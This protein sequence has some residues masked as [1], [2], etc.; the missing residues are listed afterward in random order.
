[1]S[2]GQ[3]VP[4]TKRPK[5]QN[6]PGTKSPKGKTSQGTKLPK[7]QNDLLYVIT[8]FSTKKIVLENWQ[9]TRMLGNGPQP[10]TKFMIGVFLFWGG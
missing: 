5:G 10:C 7:G 8:K 4:R 1:M 9:H 2:H 3:N 6:V